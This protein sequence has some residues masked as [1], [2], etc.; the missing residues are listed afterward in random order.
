M[1]SI[2]AGAN[3]SLSEE[4]I[5][6]NR[7]Y[8][9]NGRFCLV[10]TEV[11]P[12]VVLAACRTARACGVT[13]IL[14]PA[15]CLSLAPELLKYVDILVP[16]QDEITLLCPE[17]TLEEKADFLTR[18]LVFTL[19]ADGCYVKTAEWAESFRPKNSRPSTI[20]APA[21]PLSA[22]WPSIS[23]RAAACGRPFV[24]PPSPPG[25]ASR[26]RASFLL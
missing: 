8:F 20:P 22:P 5:Y 16:N 25:S 3:A 19:G 12:D 13:T 4:D 9:E 6:R 1:I 10:Q 26:E 24:S 15:S 21:T 7:R 17:G 23:K 2:L 14:K 18:D 11:P